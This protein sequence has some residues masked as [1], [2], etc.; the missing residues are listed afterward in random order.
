MFVV[1]L[2]KC[3]LGI[4][5]IAWNVEKVVQQLRGGGDYFFLTCFAGCETCFLCFL[6]I[7]PLSFEIVC[8]PE[9]QLYLYS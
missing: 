5:E 1:L 7:F 2:I 3:M 4:G 8:F 6:F 9:I